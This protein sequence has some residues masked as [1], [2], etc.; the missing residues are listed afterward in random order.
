MVGK[1]IEALKATEAAIQEE[2]EGVKH[3]HAS[4]RGTLEEVF[5]QV[6]AARERLEKIEPP[7][8]EAPEPAPEPKPATRTKKETTA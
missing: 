7:V 8:A 2:Y 6:T 1:T 4:A 5:T 3:W